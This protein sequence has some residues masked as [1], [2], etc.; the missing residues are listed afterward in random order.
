MKTFGLIFPLL[1]VLPGA[2]VST[3][4]IT[5]GAEPP[6]RAGLATDVDSQPGATRGQSP[7]RD[8]GDDHLPRDIDSRGLVPVVAAAR[9][10]TVD[11]YIDAGE[12]PLAAY[13]FTIQSATK[14]A[15]L[16]GL[17]GGEHPA[18]SH[19]P[20]YD[21]AALI[22]EKVIV[23]AF[24]TADVLPQGRTRVARLH[25][26]VQDEKDAEYVATLQ[27]AAGADGSVIPAKVS[28]VVTKR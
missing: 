9:F 26:Q 18:F 28:V 2:I 15:L 25:V 12:T 20:Y 17:E 22:D 11:V 5:P 16:S 24:S 14:S 27:T 13:Q 19:P 8:A 10:E 3:R 4:A 23:A 6:V 21:N 7:R 1:V